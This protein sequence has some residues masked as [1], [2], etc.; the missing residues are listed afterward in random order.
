MTGSDAAGWEQRHLTV[1]PCLASE[2]FDTCDACDGI[3]GPCRP[4]H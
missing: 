4:T 1:V 2:R 3:C